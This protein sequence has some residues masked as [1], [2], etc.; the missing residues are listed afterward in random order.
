MEARLT[1]RNN[2]VVSEHFISFYRQPSHRNW[3][4]A[5][6]SCGWSLEGV[7]AEVYGKAACHD[8][9]IKPPKGVT[10]LDI[11]DPEGMHNTLKGI[12]GE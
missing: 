1:T 9:N 5:T 6:C 10:V 3:V 4:K 2:G 8:L 7:P 12:L 11:S